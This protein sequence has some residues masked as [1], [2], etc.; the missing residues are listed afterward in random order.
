MTLRRALV[1][2]TALSTLALA[3]TITSTSQPMATAT[4]AIDFAAPS[5][6]IPSSLYG[7]FFEEISHAGDGGLYAELV[8]NRGFEDANLPPACVREGN[9]I[10]PPRTPHFDTGKPNNWRLP[11]DLTNPHPAWSLETSGGAGSIE[12]VADTPLQDATPQSLRACVK[13]ESPPGFSGRRVA[14]A[15]APG[16]TRALLTSQSSR[17]PGISFRTNQM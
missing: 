5:T 16:A 6:P 2:T 11:W 9:F 10:V 14:L 12:I 13:V 17:L 7:I 3:V 15:A 8:Q 1:L 4:V